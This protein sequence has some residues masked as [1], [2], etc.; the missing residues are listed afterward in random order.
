[1]KQAIVT[2]AALLLMTQ[3]LGGCASEPAAPNPGIKESFHTEISANGSKRFTYVL[4]VA[5]PAL[6]GP[7][8]QSASER[9]RMGKQYE[10]FGRP[11]RVNFDHALQLKLQETGFCRDGYFVIDRV[12]SPQGGELRGECREGAER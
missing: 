10:G 1:M 8:T 2:G 11:R 4:E 5:A 3:L 9:A 7:Y 6:R 12:V